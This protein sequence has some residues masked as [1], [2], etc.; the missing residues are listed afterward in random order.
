MQQLTVFWDLYNSGEEAKGGR[1]CE[2]EK[3]TEIANTTGGQKEIADS[4]TSVDADG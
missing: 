3:E 4:T 1:P 2:G